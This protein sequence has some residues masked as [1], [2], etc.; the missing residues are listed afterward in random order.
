MVSSSAP[1]TLGPGG[2]VLFDVAHGPT[3][4]PPPPEVPVDGYRGH[5]D[6]ARGVSTRDLDGRRWTVVHRVWD[7]DAL[8][9]RLASLGWRTTVELDDPGGF[10]WVR[11]TR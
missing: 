8:S 9:E 2:Q 7:L 11:A 5:H 1:S 4:D 3:P 6:P 10:H